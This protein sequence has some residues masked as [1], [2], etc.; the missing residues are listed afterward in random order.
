MTTSLLAPVGATQATDRAGNVYNV[1]AGLITVPNSVI[2][3]MLNQGYTFIGGTQ[4]IGQLL[5]ANMNVTTDQLIPINL[6]PKA[7]YNVTDIYVLN[8]STSLTTAVGGFYSA[9]SKSGTGLVAASQAYSAATDA[10]HCEK[11]TIAA[12]GAAMVLS[13]QPNIYFALTTPQGA[14][15]TADIFV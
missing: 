6:L 11:C 7:L 9:A 13:Q 14:A 15:A 12:A 2:G 5:G 1:I 10:A 4:L 8:P 3:E